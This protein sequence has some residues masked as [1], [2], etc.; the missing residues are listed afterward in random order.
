MT[1]NVIGATGQLGSRV[2]QSLLEQG[3][4]PSEI[5]V[6]VRTPAK[7]QDW[8]AQGI[9]VRQANYDNQETMIEAFKDTDVLLLIPTT[10]L[11]EPR[12]QQ[13]YKALKAAKAS[14]VKRAVFVS[15]TTARLDSKFQI[16]PFLIYGESKLRLSGLDWTILRN[17]MYLD[18]IAHWMP[19]LINMGRLPYPVKSGKIAYVSRDDLARAIASVCLNNGHSKKVYELTGPQALALSELAEIITNVTGKSIKFE[20]VTDEQYAK[21]CREGKEVLT[22]YSIEILTSLYHA[23]DNG[24]FGTVTNHIEQL[25]GMPPE[26]VETYL[27]RLLEHCHIV[28]GQP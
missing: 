27:H 2:I 17:G 12:I 24:E 1:V 4:S 26:S 21:V 15:L 11:V 7:A 14:G 18:P 3:A 8:A 20:S 22:G 16:T 23:V 6:S 5:I 9:V 13:H 25:T 10:A 19:E 28:L